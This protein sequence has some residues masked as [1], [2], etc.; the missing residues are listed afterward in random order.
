MTVAI[1]TLAVLVVA[2]LVLG[3]QKAKKKRGGVPPEQFNIDWNNI[4]GESE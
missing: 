4:V 3:V 1:L 2:V